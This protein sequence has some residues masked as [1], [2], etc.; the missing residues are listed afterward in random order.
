MATGDKTI[1]GDFVFVEQPDGTMQKFINPKADGLEL[2]NVDNTSDESK[3]V[4]NAT[5]ETLDLKAPLAS[6]AFTG[7]VT[8]ID[9]ADVGLGNVDNTSD[10]SKPIS[11]ATQAALNAKQ[12]NLISGDNI[13]TING[14]SVLG[15]GNLE[16]EAE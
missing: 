8:G 12:E 2:N 11:G 6:P 10:S 1:Q 4:S 13:K 15:S 3:P 7:A 16:I 14:Q 9:K 5:Q